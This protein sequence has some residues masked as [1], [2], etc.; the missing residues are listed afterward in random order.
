M[1]DPVAVPGMRLSATDRL[2]VATAAVALTTWTAAVSVVAVHGSV[3]ALWKIV[4]V[5]VFGALTQ[6]PGFRVARGYEPVSLDLGV[7]ALLIGFVLLG[8]AWFVVLLGPSVLIA[9]A[10]VRRRP[11]TA[12]QVAAECTAWAGAAYVA[13]DLLLP[14]STWASPRGIAVL[15]LGATVMRCAE[16]LTRALR[17]SLTRGAGHL[18]LLSERLPTELGVVAA[19]A[20]VAAGVLLVVETDSSLLSLPLVLLTVFLAVHVGAASLVDRRRTADLEQATAALD[21]LDEP[22]IAAAALRVACD[23]FH[24][25]S[26]EL[27]LIGDRRRPPRRYELTAS[28]EVLCRPGSAAIVDGTSGGDVMVALRGPTGDVGRFWFRF[29][30]SGSP[31]RREWDALRGFARAV[32]HAVLAAGLHDDVRVEAARHVHGTTHDPLTGLANRA[33]LQDRIRAAVDAKHNLTTALVLLDLDHFKE[34]NDTLGHAAGDFLL[35]RVAD[36]LGSLSRPGD[37]VSRL[38][39]DEFAVLLT[40]LESAESAGPAAEE[41]LRLLAEPV[42]YEGMKLSVEASVGLACYPADASGGDELLRRAEVAMY[43]AKADR[44]SWVRYEAAHDGSSVDRLALVAELRTALDRGEIVAH[45]QPQADLSTGQIVGVEALARWEHP[46]R[47]LLLPADFIGVAEQSGLVRPFT[48]RVLDL[49]VAECAYWTAKGSTATVAVN[50]A[51]RSLLDRQLPRDVAAVLARHALPPDRLVLEITESTAAS[52][53]EVVEEVLGRLRRLGVALSVDDFGTGYSSLAFLQR[54]KVNELKVDRSFVTGMLETESDVALVRATVQLAHSLGARAVA[55]GVEE[56]AQA[57]ALRELGCD[58]G[59]GY[60]LSRPV[61]A[62]ELDVLL[63]V[64][65]AS[66]PA[67]FRLPEPREEQ[68][69]RTKHLRAVEG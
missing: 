58:L 67:P 53:L 11:A 45:F 69:L 37:L 12:L 34:I 54:T 68:P 8:P 27:Q 29:G 46:V 31:T 66:R 26:A 65:E 39:G 35:E 63:G 21:D 56:P 30:P 13:T 61:P 28:G 59:Q 43:Q 44:G 17:S 42:S 52:E 33:L 22:D 55:E 38:G 4:F 25:R 62:E 6:L 36:R 64:D 7:G 48:L 57:E 40:G 23:V 16:R 1:A 49:A 60:W 20:A 9:H 3:P 51:A 5:A 2:V 19:N 10:L 24:C 47:G 50:L 14:A 15:A 18:R 32:G 41:V